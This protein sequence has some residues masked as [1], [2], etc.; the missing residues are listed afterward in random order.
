MQSKRGKPP[1]PA[2]VK[3]QTAQRK[4][5]HQQLQNLQQQQQQQ[6][7]QQHRHGADSHKKHSISHKHAADESDDDL[8]LGPNGQ[9][10]SRRERKNTREKQRR[11]EVNTMFDSLM[12]MLDLPKDAKADKVK[13]LQN[14]IDSIAT[15]REEAAFFRAHAPHAAGVAY[16]AYRS[17]QQPQNNSNLKQPFSTYGGG[18]LPRHDVV[19]PGPL[20]QMQ[21]QR[22][23]GCVVPSV[24]NLLKKH[25]DGGAQGIIS[26][27]DSATTS[28]AQTNN[29]SGGGG[30]GTGVFCQPTSGRRM[31]VMSGASYSSMDESKSN[32]GGV[33]PAEESVGPTYTA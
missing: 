28:A 14:A 27:N 24:G 26:L 6:Q 7:Q 1:T 13:V 33:T 4:Q 25:G 16:A 18:V 29:L 17:S 9:P 23:G 32:G 11:L 3:Q 30:S 20:T 15:L 10:M 5:L 21:Q 31:S 2:E 8:V 19:V 12:C 22:Q